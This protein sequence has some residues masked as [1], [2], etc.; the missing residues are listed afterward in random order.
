MGALRSGIQRV[1][2]NTAISVA[3]QVFQ[4]RMM[5]LNGNNT[6]GTVVSVDN[7]KGTVTLN[8]GG[9][10]ITV[11]NAGGKPFKSGDTAITDGSSFCM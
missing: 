11:P 7:T 8:Y 1:A 6:T 10:Q 5:Q 9:S 3:N 4:I 2:A